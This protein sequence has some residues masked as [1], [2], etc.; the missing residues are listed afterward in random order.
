MHLLL[1]IAAAA[2]AANESPVAPS[3]AA[4]G[5]ELESMNPFAP[6]VKLFTELAQL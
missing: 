5:E 3:K 2:A 6:R 4:G 1:V